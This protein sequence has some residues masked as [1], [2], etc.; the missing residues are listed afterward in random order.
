MG[1][2]TLDSLNP[3][4]KVNE[5]W[6]NAK[7]V[8]VTFDQQNEDPEPNDPPTIWYARWDANNN[9]KEIWDD[10]PS[11]IPSVK[12]GGFTFAI[13]D[14]PALVLDTNTP[15]TGYVGSGQARVVWSGYS[16]YD[17]NDTPA[18]NDLRRDIFIVRDEY[19]PW[20]L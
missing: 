10:G 16:T 18:N 15:S 13:G 12:E 9:Y 6:D 19:L 14:N 2:P 11:V 7:W 5:D 17:P 4:I 1:I 3:R 20:P 8:H